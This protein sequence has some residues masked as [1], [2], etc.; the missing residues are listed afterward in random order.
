[1]HIKRQHHKH[2]LTAHVNQEIYKMMCVIK[3]P[4]KIII[5]LIEAKCDCDFNG[6]IS[7]DTFTSII[8]I[9]FSDVIPWNEMLIIFIVSYVLIT[10]TIHFLVLFRWFLILYMTVVGFNTPG[11]VLMIIFSS[12]FFLSVN[13]RKRYFITEYLMLW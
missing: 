4:M 10:K 6:K 3:I 1:M 11:V 7:G 5:S 12:F 9:P 8:W 2:K 13:I